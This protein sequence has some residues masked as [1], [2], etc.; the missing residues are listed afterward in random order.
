MQTLVQSVERAMGF[1]P[2]SV[3]RSAL[4]HASWLPLRGP[5]PL[6]RSP[7]RGHTPFVTLCR[8]FNCKNGDKFGAGDG[9]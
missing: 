5:C 8:G 4:K 3:A 9:I 6:V 2:H 7:R 1:E